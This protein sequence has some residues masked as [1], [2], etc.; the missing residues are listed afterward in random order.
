L[1]R[2]QVAKVTGTAPLSQ[3]TS[4]G[5]E[6]NDV[7]TN[8]IFTY[9][10]TS[11][12]LIGGLPLDIASN[13]ATLATVKTIHIALTI[14]NNAVTDPKTRQPI[15]TNFEGEVSLNNCS[16]ATTGIPPMSCQ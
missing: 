9:Y 11:G 7:I 6:V 14:Q 4:W 5:T 16:M 13:G 8:P 15:Q 3:G 10:D 1:Q 12:N 2:S